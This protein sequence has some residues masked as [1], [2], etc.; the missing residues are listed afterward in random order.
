MEDISYNE[1]RLGQIV[2]D[3]SNA[4]TK[5]EEIRG[6]LNASI[7]SIVRVWTGSDEVV[8]KRD[9]DFKSIQEN[10]ELIC[11][12]LTATTDYLNQKNES[13]KA[14]STSYRAS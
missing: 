10:M 2:E 12:N 14:A 7:T 8:T 6:L 9:A 3:F 11:N 4:K 1:S 5:S 13:F